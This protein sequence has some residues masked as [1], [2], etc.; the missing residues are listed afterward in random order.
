MVKRARKPYYRDEKFLEQLGNT[1]RALRVAKGI[2]QEE[3][4]I[5]FDYADYSQINRIELG[6]VNFSISYLP[7]IA[8]ALEVKVEELIKK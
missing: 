6:K 3:L 4:A 2:S 8:Q 5:R 1:I 7:L